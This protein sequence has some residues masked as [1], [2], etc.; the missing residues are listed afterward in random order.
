[1][2]V[3]DEHRGSLGRAIGR[4]IAAVGIWTL[5]AVSAHG[6]VKPAVIDFDRDVRPIL[7]NNCYA[8]HCF[9][10]NKRQAGLRLDLPGA[11]LKPLPSGRRAIV[12]GDLPCS[13]DGAVVDTGQSAAELDRIA[14]VVTGA[15]VG[16]ALTGTVVLDHGPG[17]GRRAL[18]LVPDHS[19]PTVIALIDDLADLAG[20]SVRAYVR[21][22]EDARDIPRAST[23]RDLER[24]LVTVDHLADLERQASGIERVTKATLM[25]G[26][27]DF[28]QLHVLLG[29]PRHTCRHRCQQ[30]CLSVLAS[31][32]ALCPEETRVDEATAGEPN[33]RTLRRMKQTMIFMTMDQGPLLGFL[34]VC[35]SSTVAPR[36][37]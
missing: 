22:I 37:G 2:W 33:G 32:I 9:D 27:D 15:A 18:T 5:A 10:A 36:T 16:I 14:A 29:L 34:P 31:M 1:M 20:Q 28:R 25:R 30:C 17:Q 19:N 24:L 23:R 35:W 13:V 26:S 21:C 4:G 12:P 7:S 11:P 6:E 3:A 8:C